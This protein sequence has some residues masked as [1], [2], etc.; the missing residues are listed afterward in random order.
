MILI[1]LF[2]FFFYLESSLPCFIG[3]DEVV[4]EFRERF[5]TSLTDQQFGTLIDE[6]IEVSCNNV[7]TRLYDQ[8]QYFS[9]GTFV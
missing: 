6:L 4:A 2:L 9:N 1:H 8:Y 7:Y 5:H 3:G